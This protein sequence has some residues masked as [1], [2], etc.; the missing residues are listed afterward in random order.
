M[1]IRS[2]YDLCNYWQR[3]SWLHVHCDVYKPMYLQTKLM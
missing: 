2:L 1:V 3:Y